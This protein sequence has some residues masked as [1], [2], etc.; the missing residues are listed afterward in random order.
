MKNKSKILLA[1]FF[2]QSAS[3][4]LT[5][6]SAVSNLTYSQR[7][8]T[9]LVDIRYDLTL[10]AG[11]TAKVEFSFSHDDGVTFP[12]TCTSVTG[13]AG[14]TVSGGLAKTVVW[15]AEVDWNQQ[16]TD[17][18]CI[19]IV[20]TA[21]P[22]DRIIDFD[23]A[24]V[25]FKASNIEESPSWWIKE[26]Y[27]QAPSFVGIPGVP[28]KYFADKYE[29]TNWQWDKVVE[30]AQKNGYDLQKTPAGSNPN[31]P[32]TM[33]SMAEVVK[34]LNARSEM[35]GKTP[36]FYVDPMETGWDE[37]GDGKLSAGTDSTWLT[38]EEDMKM[39]DGTFDWSL[40]VNLG[41][42][43][44]LGWIEWDPNFNCQ[45][46][47][48]EPFVDRNRNGKYEP[49]EYADING[50][51]RRDTGLT[52]VCRTGDV[53]GW[54]QTFDPTGASLQ[55]MWGWGIQMHMKEAANGY[56]LTRGN[57]W[58]PGPDEFR[59]LA[60]GGRT[61]QGSYQTWEDWTQP[62]TMD[63][64]TGE[65]KPVMKTGIRYVE[66]WPWGSES[67]EIKAEIGQYAVTPYGSN[68]PAGIQPVGGRKPNG[69]GLHDMIGN[70]AEMSMDWFVDPTGLADPAMGGMGMGDP[71]GT[72]FALG[73]SWN[74]LPFGGSSGMYGNPNVSMGGVSP[75]SV[76]SSG[77]TSDAM[78]GPD[79]GFRAIRVQF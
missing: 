37:N 17:R 27:S 34:W 16:F 58:C 24:E 33:V 65:W 1:F 26:F 28:K 18:G 15:D 6:S 63:P 39:W 35:E 42:G 50:N 14:P 29:V 76:M 36:V 64:I 72:S 74:N 9:K 31:L 54:F 13:D 4:V 53:S 56:R 51:G 47:A 46:D 62:G 41:Q 32:R 48:G 75:R 57:S 49:Q 12:V 19:K 21:S 66:E 70:I 3:L 78:G 44:Q 10:D 40:I 59:F 61:E 79:I 69:Y 55:Q 43:R 67:P 71:R 52:I 8:G 11:Q 25:S 38:P 20:F 7:I 45:W 77:Q 2:Y 22:S 60:M 68:V 23:L 5:A 30:W 73:G